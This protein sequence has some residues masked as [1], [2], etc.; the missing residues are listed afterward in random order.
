MKHS[1][2]EKVEAILSDFKRTTEEI[3]SL[4]ELRERLG[5]GRPLRI[6]YGVD[7]TSPFIHIGH[8]V[9]LWMQ[10]RLQEEG[11]KLIFLI[12]D[13]TT[14]IGDPTGR[15]HAR[16]VIPKEEIDRNAELFI[17]QASMVLLTDPAVFEVRRN[18]E[19]FDQMT[20]DRFL[21]LLSTVTHSRLIARDMFQKRLEH[22]LEIHMHEMIYPILQGY[23]SYMLE[24][25][26]TIIGTDQLFNEMMGRFFQS[27]FGQEPQIIITTRITPGI[28]GKA[29]Q[30]K[31]LDNHIALGHSPRDK[32]GRAMSIPDQLILDYF[33]VY[34]GVPV[35][36]MEAIRKQIARDPMNCKL[37]LAEE[38]VARYH[39]HDAAK[40]EKDWFV[41]TFSRRHTPQDIE[42]M[43]LGRT[44][45]SIFE[46]LRAHFPRGPVSNAE[47]HRLLKQNAVTVDDVKIDDPHRVIAI[48]DEPV[49]KV[50]KRTWF[51]VLE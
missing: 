37:R 2:D 16:P 43:H 28:D 33:E 8:A 23:D 36:E 7:V 1:H 24:S 13:F 5:R 48:A 10:R 42:L 22:G 9:N 15:D 30:S 45:A 47:I 20:T 17:E 44:E 21:S 26:L 14:R 27:R 18:S 6:K 51:K 39:G 3:H 46:I 19:W 41:E 32:F 25:D 40:A 4:E 12:G 11:H 38:L 50:G 31:S 29:K 34:T 35:R 49:I